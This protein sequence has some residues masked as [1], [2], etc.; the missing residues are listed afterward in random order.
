[1]S[2]TDTMEMICF[3]TVN[4]EDGTQTL[5]VAVGPLSPEEAVAL[6]MPVHEAVQEVLTSVMADRGIKIIND[7]REPDLNRETKLQ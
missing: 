1:M 5:V 2:N 3:A 7:T 4:P 6:A